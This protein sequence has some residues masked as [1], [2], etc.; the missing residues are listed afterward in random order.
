MKTFDVAI[1]GAGLAGLHAAYLLRNTGLSV[2][3]MES[4]DRVGGRVLGIADTQHRDHHHDLGPTWV[5][6][7]H[8]ATQ[9]LAEQLDLP[10]MAQFH[11]GDALFQGPNAAPVKRMYGAGGMDLFRLRHGVHSL[12]AGLAEALPAS[13]LHLS[14]NVKRLTREQ[15]LWC[16]DA[17]TPEGVQ[18]YQAK[19]LLL[20]LPPRVIAKRFGSQS[21]ITEP[22]RHALTGTP[23][24]MAAQA[25][26]I[27]TYEQP[28][29]RQDGLSGQ[30]FSHKGPMIEMHDASSD[31]GAPHALFGFIGIP[32][33]IR[34]QIGDVS[35]IKAC[36]HQL[37]ELYGENASNPTWY[38][39]TDWAVDEDIAVERDINE[40]P[41]HPAI[42]LTPFHAHMAEHKFAL[43]G[44]EFSEREAG[45]LEGAL[46]ASQQGVENLLASDRN[47]R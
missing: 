38:H 15:E 14:H 46:I 43:I 16:L 4:K 20:A 41:Q 21:W 33:R 24:W 5:F 26:F 22:L 17:D 7:H 30:A 39:L 37:V 47:R 3:L 9:R 12:V 1:V 23:T 44:S 6:P 36:L 18:Q 25:K 10:L 2:G 32:A 11:Q 29:W 13:T 34:Q 27:A 42:D 19:H 40:R 45:Y 35:L 8:V 31:L 28:F